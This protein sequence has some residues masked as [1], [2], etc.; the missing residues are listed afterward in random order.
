M[1]PASVPSITIAGNIRLWTVEN[2]VHPM[3]APRYEAIARLDSPN[4][5][6]GEKT[7]VEVPDP[8]NYN[9]FVEAG[10]VPGGVTRPTFNII[11]RYPKALSEALRLGRKQCRIDTY[12][13]VGECR[14]PQDFSE[15]WE[16]VLFFPSGQI[17]SW[18]GDG[19][20][21]TQSDENAPA[22][23][24]LALTAREIYEFGQM[25]FS[26]LAADLTVREALTID[27]CDKESCGDCD[28]DA[29]DGCQKVLVTMAGVGATPGTKPKLLYSQDGGSTF[30]SMDINTMFSNESPS[31]AACIGSYY[32]IAGNIS[33][34]LHYISVDDLFDGI[35]TFTETITGF[36]ANGK[37]LAIDSIDA[38][39]TWIAAED[40]YVYFTANPT[41]GVEVLTAGSVTTQDLQDVD[42]Y[43]SSQLLA[44]GDLNA[45]IYSRDGG[46]T[47]SAV[48]GPDPGIQLTCCH[49]WSQD[50]WFVGTAQGKL[51][52]TENA[53]RTWV[54]KQLPGS[55]SRINDIDFADEA[56][57]YLIALQGTA[58]FVY[59]T[60][61]G[62]YEWTVLPD[63]RQASIPANDTL[64]SLAV[65]G[66]GKNRVFAA[67]LDDD[68]T[69]GIV[70]K[71]SA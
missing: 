20:G 63:G 37:P 48:V 67:G 62:G 60:I 51:W 23:E 15:G 47:W 14:N 21:A 4:W 26:H 71:A 11:G 50:V 40:G 19:F 25:A 12:A 42:A 9:R 58:G 2:G 53:G 59:R 24:T 39:H 64:N 10:T 49:M 66:V 17:S 18:A 43:N 7:R 45:V 55:V 56:E 1:S 68:G 22:N 54:R 38:R 13:L 34:S 3:R 69:S 46:D 30:G 41:M 32:V 5:N 65:C 44:V 6:F 31:D 36:V 27:V 8:S 57:G 52:I 35:G 16:K 33:D 29:S 28:G 61:T 70:V